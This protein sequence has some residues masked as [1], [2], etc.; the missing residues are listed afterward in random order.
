MKTNVSLGLTLEDKTPHSLD[1]HFGEVGVFSPSKFPDSYSLTSKP[2]WI[3][4]C[5]KHF[6]LSQSL[7]L[8]MWF[9]ID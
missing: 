9:N 6:S 8:I 1:S 4:S 2:P 5:T 3:H 7:N